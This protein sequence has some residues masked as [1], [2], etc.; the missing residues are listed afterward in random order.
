MH[1]LRDTAVTGATERATSILNV[2]M[3][4]ICQWNDDL[5]LTKDVK[6]VQFVL[7][8]AA[9]HVYNVFSG[10]VH[11]WYVFERTVREHPDNRALCF[12]KPTGLSGDDA[13]VAEEYTYG[14][15][16][17]MVLRLSE[18]LVHRYG[19][20]VGDTIGMDYT[21]K[22]MFIVLWLALWNVGAL[23]AF[24][25][26]NNVGRPLTHCIKVAGMRMVFIDPQCSQNATDTEEMIREECP[27]VILHFWDEDAIMAEI[28]D[29]NSVQFRLEDSKRSVDEKDYQAGALIY[30]SGT[31]GLPK[32]AI[33]SWRKAG[34]GSSLYGYIV[35][36]TSND[37]VFTSMPLYHSTASMLGVCAAFNH[38]ACVALSVKFSVSTIWTQVKLT[39]AT[40]LQYVGE[41]CRYLLNSPVHKDERNHLL[42]V[43]Y[44]NGLRVDIWEQ[45]KERF[46]I[47]A[48]GEFYAATE[49]PIA[50]TSF[51]EG[52]QGIG[53]CRN[54]GYLINSILQFQQT[55]IKMDSEDNSTE[56]RNGKGFCE[57]TE[58][59]EPGELIMNIFT[60]KHT[61]RMFQGY[62]GNKKE[63]ESKILR[64]VFHKGDAWFRSGDLLKS[65][66]RG[67]WYFV[68]RLGDTFRW[69]SENVSTVEVE[70]EIAKIESVRET[71]VVGVKVP[72]HE[73]RAGFAVLD[74]DDKNYNEDILKQVAH[75]SLP[76]YAVP[77]FIKFDTI[78]HSDNHKVLKKDYREQVLP[79]GSTGG[80]VLYWLSKE[81]YRELT[82]EDWKG[83]EEGKLKI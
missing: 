78:T 48:I 55:L 73:G 77:I 30:T 51:Q 61:E 21:N 70:N 81:G 8:R 64:D 54:Y 67:L 27:D 29:P 66:A 4:S 16:Y 69:K 49:S 60:A 44:G 6:L 58:V 19:V 15:L 46:G 71:V 65:D 57:V 1:A 68:D 74:V 40:H 31:T 11:Y 75:V 33:M 26:Y 36:L 28:K 39:R 5:Q 80:D 32:S 56:W 25:N 14:E 12:A 63:T 76:R 18:I 53:A 2:T 52:N 9:R 41:V 24:L 38:G 37:T 7:R 13:F 72:N 35:R 50:L 42:K 20:A 3:R 23:P 82:E 10:R 45:F 47:E 62:L 59:G 34:F 17:A 83:I 43:A 79:K 22:P